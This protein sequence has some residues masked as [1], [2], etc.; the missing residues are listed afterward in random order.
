MR[1]PFAYWA[2]EGR[3]SVARLSGERVAAMLCAARRRVAWDAVSHFFYGLDDWRDAR[4]MAEIVAE[5]RRRAETQPVQSIASGVS[6]NDLPEPLAC[7]VRSSDQH[8][9]NQEDTDS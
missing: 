2:V 5:K 7:P 9:P 8:R 3:I 4:S 6:Q 1:R